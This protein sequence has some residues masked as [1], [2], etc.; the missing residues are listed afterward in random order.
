MIL[1]GDFLSALQA[2]AAQRTPEWSA[3]KLSCD[4]LAEMPVRYFN[5]TGSGIG[6]GYQGGEYFNALM[7]LGVCRH[8]VMSTDPALATRYGMRMTDILR[9][10]SDP[11]RSPE[12]G[13]DSGYGLRFYGVGMAYGYDWAY[14]L[15][16]AVTK[17]QVWTA[18]NRWIH[19][20]ETDPCCD[21]EW[22]HPQSNYFAGYYHAKAAGAIATEGDNPKAE[23]MWDDWIHDQQ[24]TRV[25]PFFAVN[26]AG[27]GWP[28]GFPNY[29]PFALLNHSLVTMSVMTGKGIDLIHASQPYVFPIE[30]GDY[31]MQFTWP[32][33]GHTDDR[34][35]AHAVAAGQAPAG[36]VNAGMFQAMAGILEFWHAP[37]AAIFHGYAAAVL[38]KTQQKNS[39]EWQKFLLWNPGAPAAPLDGLPRSHFARGLNHVAARSHWNADATWLS[40]VSGTYINNPSQGEQMFDAGSLA[41][42]RGGT[43]LLVNAATWLMHN[44]PGTSDGEVGE[45][46]VYRANYGKFNQDATAGNR[47]LYSIFYVRHLDAASQPVEPY[48]E[49]AFGPAEAQTHISS[50]EDAGDYVLAI[51]SNL[52]DMYRSGSTARFVQRW[53]RKVFFLRPNQILV[54]DETETGDAGFDQFLAWTFSGRP[55]EDK[56]HGRF[57][58]T[59][60][61]AA[62]DAKFAG[63]MTQVLPI[64]AHVTSTDL[65]HAGKVWRAEVR[66]P[67]RDVRQNWL[68][69]FDLA[70]SPERVATAIPVRVIS[71]AA[72]GTVLASSTQISV[73]LFCD[74]EV[75]GRNSG[76]QYRV[77]AASAHHFL[78][79]L[80]GNAPYK[81]L[82]SEQGG[83]HVITV[84]PGGSLHASSGGVLSF[85]IT[86][87]G[88]VAA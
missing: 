27:G 65:F 16:D 75:T 63:S 35:A 68:T 23:V 43:P 38:Q 51:G 34:G 37:H 2:R 56:N 29:G 15:L 48:G 13:R 54:H 66:P 18:I 17:A 3:L 70:S 87:S 82:V 24:E 74:N 22:E 41:L 47:D 7:N 12:P 80:A 46:A 40:F 39:A 84:S 58:V 45:K 50:F 60:P 83:E 78:I 79:G 52:E 30:S 69:V 33:L 62:V 21:W 8:V 25:Q 72:S 81:V 5:Q 42:V 59:H 19:V 49:G 1:S 26:L 57:D 14:D 28:E 31:L 85:Q 64:G 53:T 77:P 11:G 76:L 10:M 61:P 4:A 20:F 73:V 32:S 6:E 55:L 67:S 71:G 9:H 36:T 44:S 88:G 86:A